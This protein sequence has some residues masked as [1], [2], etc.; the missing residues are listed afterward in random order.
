MIKSMIYLFWFNLKNILLDYRKLF[1]IF[2]LPLLILLIIGLLLN[3]ENNIDSPTEKINIG[4]VD[5]EQTPISKML[6]G[7]ITG[8]DTIS[9]LMSFQILEESIAI[10]KLKEGKLTAYIV[11]PE[12]FSTGLLNMENPPLRIVNNGE[13]IFEFFI[14]HQTVESF[15]KYVTYVE[16]CT[17]SEY[18]AIIEM[19]YSVEEA[20]KVNDAVSLK[21]IFDTLG[22]KTLFDNIPIFEFPSVSSLLYHGISVIVL[23]LFYITTIGS[24]D[25]INDSYS[26]VF[27][28]IKL[29]G[30]SSFAY[31]ISKAIAY[32]FVSTAWIFLTILIYISIFKIPVDIYILFLTLL[33]LCFVLNSF[34]IF[35]GRLINNK[36]NFLGF[37]SILIVILAFTGGTFFP[38]SLMPFS[39]SK[40]IKY[41]PN[42]I[43]SKD[44]IY[45]IKDNYIY[46]KQVVVILIF[47]LTGFLF[48][49]ITG[50]VSSKGER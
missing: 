31:Y 36:N 26:G 48:L 47:I 12:N 34:W 45:L 5:L 11:I 28:K 24:V 21:L 2:I 23:I 43:I 27:K 46:S 22:R 3:N 19:G 33:S 10:D 39:I 49:K 38:I 16:I 30:V 17:A 29:S 40:Y 41:V 42:S 32:T 37:N 9:N 6:I 44:I 15:S 50:F 13:N 18:E 25:A 20:L 35:I 7:N 8:E 4:I 14:I 1:L